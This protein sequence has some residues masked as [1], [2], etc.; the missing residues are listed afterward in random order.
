METRVFKTTPHQTL[1]GHAQG[2]TSALHPGARTQ[3]D[4]GANLSSKVGRTGCKLQ[5]AL[6]RE[7]CV[8]GAQSWPWADYISIEMTSYRQ[9]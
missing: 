9:A 3:G 8:P 7:Q 6:V 1:P 2:G 5:Q 4:L